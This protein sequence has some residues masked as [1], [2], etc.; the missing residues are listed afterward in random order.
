MGVYSA[1]ILRR[2]KRDEVNC[3]QPRM[4]EESKA[5]LDNEYP[6]GGAWKKQ[7]TS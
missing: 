7:Q 6:R 4:R 5:R 1:V 2:L 3:I